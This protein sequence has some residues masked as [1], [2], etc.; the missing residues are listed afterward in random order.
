MAILP[1][2]H[3]FMDQLIWITVNTSFNYWNMQGDDVFLQKLLQEVDK[4]VLD[5]FI[6]RSDIKVQYHQL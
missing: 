4:T 5:T 6:I 3:S 2:S 1:I